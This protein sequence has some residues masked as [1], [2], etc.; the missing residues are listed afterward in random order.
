M[1]TRENNYYFIPNIHFPLSVNETREKPTYHH[2]TLL[3]GELVLENRNVSEPVL[4]Y[5]I[6]DALAI[7]GKCIIDRPLPKRLGYITE[8]VM[9][10]FDNFKKHNPDIVNSLNSPL[11]LDS[12]QC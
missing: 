8:N 11:K 6:F 4:R 9:K 5:V 7:H 2:G 10:P 12:K 1:V 3:D